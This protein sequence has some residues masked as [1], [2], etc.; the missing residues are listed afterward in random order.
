LISRCSLYLGVALTLVPQIAFCASPV[1]V[2]TDLGAVRDAVT[3][4]GGRVIELTQD[5]LQFLRGV[6]VMNPEPPGG[7]PYGDRAMLV[8]VDGH[9]DGLV[10]FVDGDQ[11]CNTMHAP[12]EVL[13]LMHVVGTGNIDH[14]GAG[15]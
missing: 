12:S 7:L 13:L 3:A 1:D 6:Y 4:E 5:Q 2:C 11:A 15:L 8:Q 10:L 9:S 14:H